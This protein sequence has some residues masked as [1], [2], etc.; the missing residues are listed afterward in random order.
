MCQ[1]LILSQITADTLLVKY[2]V[3]YYFMLTLIN[4]YLRRL[5]WLKK[6]I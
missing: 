6:M 5:I 2:F 4:L 1:K 3:L